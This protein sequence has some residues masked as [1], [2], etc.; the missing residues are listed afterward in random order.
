MIDDKNDEFGTS[1]RD[2]NSDKKENNEV[3]P[4]EI[5]KES[6]KVVETPSEHFD[7]ENELEE[8]EDEILSN[9]SSRVSQLVNTIP[10]IQNQLRILANTN[11]S[12]VQDEVAKMTKEIVNN[13]GSGISKNFKNIDVL[14]QMLISLNRKILMLERNINK[15]QNR[16]STV[17]I[18]DFWDKDIPNYINDES[19]I[20][21][22]VY[23]ITKEGS[24]K[25]DYPGPN[26]E[27][28]P[29]VS[30]SEL[31]SVLSDVFGGGKY[32][33]R[34]RHKPTGK[35]IGSK[36][37]TLP[38]IKH[39]NE[40]VESQSNSNMVDEISKLVTTI[41]EESKQQIDALKQEIQ[42]LKANTKESSMIELIKA[43]KPTQ[44]NNNEMINLINTT[45]QNQLNMMKAQFDST[46]K[47]I[48][49]NAKNNNA[50]Q[51]NI[52][53]IFSAVSNM[54]TEL[55]K[56]KITSLADV[57]KGKID[58]EKDKLKYNFELKKMA[59]KFGDIEEEAVGTRHLE[60]RI[61]QLAKS[62]QTKEQKKTF[63]D[64]LTEFLGKAVGAYQQIATG[65]NP[66]MQAINKGGETEQYEQSID[67]GHTVEVEEEEEDLFDVGNGEVMEK[68]PFRGEGR[69]GFRN[70]T[71]GR[72]SDQTDSGYFEDVKAKLGVADS[73]DE[74]DTVIIIEQDDSTKPERV[75]E[76]LSNDRL[77]QE[78]ESVED[79]AV[80]REDFNDNKASVS[81]TGD[82][83]VVKSDGGS[84]D[85]KTGQ[86]N[87]NGNTN[88][89]QHKSKKT[90]VE[91]SS[92]DDVKEHVK[93]G[94]KKRKTRS[95][96]DTGANGK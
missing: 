92:N 42:T 33:L 62:L 78:K 6:S 21:V 66:M 51:P 44:S 45:F 38:E 1:I 20:S 43:L 68:K 57:Q 22:S 5:E 81:N 31:R 53:T 75:E 4:I 29:P 54:M 41:R 94:S 48:M 37:I 56:S 76:T 36:M 67:N 82:S 23:R 28:Q 40:Q 61:D 71:T 55:E 26:G 11:H 83:R 95:D 85:R 89:N 93:K 72:K 79:V 39:N 16:A 46:I 18:G 15:K 13:L 74:E 35:Y 80:S 91:T 52:E 24:Y 73:D 17:N 87:K 60:E 90:T 84:S 3:Y 14:N 8:D 27:I 32:I 77:Q 70:S 65:M 25:V 64:S 9:I 7:I 47:M 69:R 2:M 49:E 63:L 19:E 30:Y 58:L 12:T 96:N 86:S 10:D 59:G 34:V 88:D 50:G